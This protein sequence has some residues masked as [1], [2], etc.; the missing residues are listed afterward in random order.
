[1][2]FQP[3]LP[4][5]YS[6]SHE[7]GRDRRHL[8][9]LHVALARSRRE[10]VIDEWDDR[11]IR[12][13]QMWEDVIIE[14]AS[15]SRVFLLVITNRF[16]DSD[17]CI[18][19][20]LTIARTLLAKRAAAIAP[21]LAED[22]D[23]QIKELRDLQIIMPFDR[24]VSRSKRDEAWTAVAREVRKIADDLVRGT[25]FT[26][27]PTGLAPVPS[28]LPFTIGRA[29]QA[30]T[31]EGALRAAPRNRPFVSAL[32]GDRQGQNEF[33]DTLLMDGGPVRDI[34][35]LSSATYRLK[36]DGEV[37]AGSGESVEALLDRFLTSQVEPS[38]LSANREGIV[39]SL[40]AHPGLSVIHCE[41]SAAEWEACSRSRFQQFLGYW[42]NWPD[43]M[44][45]HSMIVFLTIHAETE[46]L[47]VPGGLY[48]PLSSVT[49]KG[50]EKWLATPE[51]RSRFLVDR[52]REHLKKDV[53][54]NEDRLPME[55]FAA[56]FLPLLQ[57]LQI[58]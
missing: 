27:A 47:A 35:K 12:G 46:G 49:R 2:E 57:K 38:P 20:E 54:G 15:Q 16:I 34:L 1:M 43:L 11:K 53:F 55:A 56:G 24:P 22:A 30:S 4:A 23:W 37:W 44:S 29:A 25:Y 5:F 42:A 19:T 7:F 10:R 41:L 9:E 14:R 36:I 33:I 50:V 32:T 31:F 21:I 13:G 58:I 8:D 6:Y 51:A 39:A 52:L 26:N 17:F 45:D 48:L 3:P 18:G 40:N 28:L